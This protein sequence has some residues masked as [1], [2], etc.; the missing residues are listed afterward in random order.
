MGLGEP[1]E[2]CGMKEQTK[3]KPRKWKK[4]IKKAT[5]GKFGWSYYVRLVS[6]GTYH[7]KNQVHLLQMFAVL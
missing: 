1:R 4:G 3:K 6:L 5:E 2:F 7:K